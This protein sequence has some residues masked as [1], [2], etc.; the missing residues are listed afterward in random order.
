[1]SRDPIAIA[2]VMLD[3]YGDPISTES[4]KIP[5]QVL[6]LHY[7]I[8]AK[9]LDWIADRDIEHSVPQFDPIDLL[10]LVPSIWFFSTAVKLAVL[11]LELS[12]GIQPAK[13]R[14]AA[15]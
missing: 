4:S 6:P 1:L 10:A 12:F 7:F 3:T 8:N 2:N 13:E 9:N 5:Q 14:Q 11:K 15:I